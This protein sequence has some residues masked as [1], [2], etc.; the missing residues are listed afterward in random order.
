MQQSSRYDKDHASWC[1]RMERYLLLTVIHTTNHACVQK[2]VIR[3]VSTRQQQYDR[4]GEDSGDAFGPES[5]GL[6]LRIQHTH[7]CMMYIPWFLL[8]CSHDRASS[9]CTSTSHTNTCVLCSAFLF[10]SH[11]R[12]SSTTTSLCWVMVRCLDPSHLGYVYI[13]K[14]SLMRRRYLLLLH[15]VLLMCSWCTIPI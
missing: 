3:H 5:R 10:C 11:G 2:Q 8:I 14:T 13:S 4:C 6:W 1:L 9:T 7:T 12:A 15:E